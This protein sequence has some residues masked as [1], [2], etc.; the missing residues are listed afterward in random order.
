VTM[1]VRVVTLTVMSGFHP[2]ESEREH[3]LLCVR[4]PVTDFYRSK[5]DHPGK[6]LV[7][8]D[9][10]ASL[11]HHSLERGGATARRTPQSEHRFLLRREPHELTLFSGRN[12]QIFDPVKIAGCG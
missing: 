3:V 8:D 6:R 9:T 11:R 12:E 1:Y 2:L 5:V 4:D 7:Y 10:V